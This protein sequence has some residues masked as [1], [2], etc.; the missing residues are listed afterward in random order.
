MTRTSPASLR[1]RIQTKKIFFFHLRFFFPFFSLF[2]C[3]L[4]FGVMKGSTVKFWH[5]QTYWKCHISGRKFHR[6]E[7]SW[8]ALNLNS[9]PNPSRGVKVGKKCKGKHFGKCLVKRGKHSYNFGFRLFVVHIKGPG[10]IQV[11]GTKLSLF[12]LQGRNYPRL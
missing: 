9:N 5:L 4:F 1:G 6:V 11:L 12:H 3:P 10:I 8:N 7:K 2:P